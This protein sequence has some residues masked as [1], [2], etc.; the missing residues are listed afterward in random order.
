MKFFNTKNRKKEIFR[1]SSKEIKIYSCG[2]TVYDFAHIGNLRAFVFND[3]LVRYLKFKGFKTKLVSNITDIDDKT[4]LGAQKAKMPLSD[5]TKK[6][7]KLF[8]KDIGKLNIQKADKYPRA[9]EHIKEMQNL[10]KILWKK[11][12]AYEK[13]GSIYFDISKFKNYGKFSKID[14]AGLKEGARVSADLYNKESSGDFVLWKKS[15]NGEPSW[16]LAIG[17]KLLVGRPGWHIECSAMAMKYLGETID[18]HL[19][20]IDLVFPHH[21]NEIAQSEAATGKEF[22]RFWLHNEHLLVDGAKMSKSLGNFY[23]LPD[24]IKKG[25]DPLAFRYL[26]LQTHYRSKMNFTFKALDAAQ[27]TLDEIRVLDQRQ[28]G[29]GTLL[30]SHNTHNQGLSLPI[31]KALDDDLDTPK[32]LAILHKAND[33]NL[34]VYFDKVLGLGLK[35]LKTQNS[36]L[37]TSTQISKLL[38]ERENL[39]KAGEFEKADKI[40]L[41]IEKMG[42]KIEDTKKGT[43]II[44][45]DKN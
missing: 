23:T 39:R 12:Y 40:R 41:E 6:Y 18:F 38:K 1:P 17:G 45:I 24:L 15:K 33:F 28:K 37:K 31:V 8:F 10:I 21:E 2:P 27:N 44:N 3:I 9:T 42:Y 25:Y 30:L 5:F 32:A 11:G 7:E 16:Q 19:G 20:G 36:K 34:W 13:D 14:L 35:K 29:Q 26:C 22:S 4:I 43:D